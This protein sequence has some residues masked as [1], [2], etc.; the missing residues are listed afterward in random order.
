[1]CILEFLHL[2]GSIMKHDEKF[3]ADSEK[4][5]PS[6]AIRQKLLECSPIE[7]NFLEILLDCET[8]RKPLI[9]IPQNPFRSFYE[10][11][12]DRQFDWTEDEIM[13]VS[14]N[15]RHNRRN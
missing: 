11:S 3:E 14:K 4:T 15:L 7:M 5:T 10:D 8:C 6:D 12:C 1:M 9:Q 13:Q 2:G